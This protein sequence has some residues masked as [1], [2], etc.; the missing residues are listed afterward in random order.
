MAFVLY[1]TGFGKE[2]R[3]ENEEGN[4]K[5]GED[6]K[7]ETKQA[8]CYFSQDHLQ[9]RSAHVC[10]V[11]LLQHAW[12]ILKQKVNCSIFSSVA[13]RNMPRW[14]TQAL[15]FWTSQVIHEMSGGQAKRRCEFLWHF[16]GIFREIFSSM[17]FW[18]SYVCPREV[19]PMCEFTRVTTQEERNCQELLST[20]Y[21]PF[22][23]ARG[24]SGS[25]HGQRQRGGLQTEGPLQHSEFMA[26]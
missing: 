19:A 5:K 6:S 17:Y 8:A 2:D 26:W 9:T 15:H 14:D 1:L 3:G 16:G 22:P 7:V 13:G 11:A 20:P 25:H 21:S 12:P 23:S 24:C 4:E 18:K 10:S